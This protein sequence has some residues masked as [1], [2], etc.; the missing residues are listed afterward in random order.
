MIEVANKI[1]D[2]EIVCCTLHYKSWM[3]RVL[4]KKIRD[5]CEKQGLNYDDMI[6]AKNKFFMMVSEKYGDKTD[7]FDAIEVEISNYQF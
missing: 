7:N 4:D 1:D 3:D 2:D 6:K 5:R